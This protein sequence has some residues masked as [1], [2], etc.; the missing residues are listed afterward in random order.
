MLEFHCDKCG[1]LVK[2]EDAVQIRIVYSAYAPDPDMVPTYREL[3]P[4]CAFDLDLILCPGAEEEERAALK[5][6]WG[7]KDAYEPTQLNRA[8]PVMEVSGTRTSTTTVN[9]AHLPKVKNPYGEGR[10]ITIARIRAGMKQWQIGEKCFAEQAAVSS[11]ETGKAKPD[12]EQLEKILPELPE[13]RKAGCNAYC[14]H[15]EECLSRGECYYGRYRVDK[16][17]TGN[18]GR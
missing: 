10:C 12:W 1:K 11:W 17:K 3:C 13:I 5:E 2:R 4:G 7:W 8:D 15:A 18:G 6:S 16:E 9:K 14:N